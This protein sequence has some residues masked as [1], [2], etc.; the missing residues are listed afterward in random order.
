MTEEL[1]NFE[2][3]TFESITD[4]T[5]QTTVCGGNLWKTSLFQV[6]SGYIEKIFNRS[7]IESVKAVQVAFYE[8]YSKV[9]F[10]LKE[11]HNSVSLKVS[12]LNVRTSPPAGRCSRLSPSPSAQLLPRLWQ[13]SGG[14][15]AEQS[16]A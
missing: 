16:T 14:A 11:S 5:Q 7:V 6:E 4:Y 12:V 8:G 13:S 10:T 2:I 3:D 1:L 15:V 9:V